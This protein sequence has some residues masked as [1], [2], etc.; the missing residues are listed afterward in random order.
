MKARNQVNEEIKPINLK[1][2]K[3][4]EIYAYLP[5]GVMVLME[6]NP[7]VIERIIDAPAAAIWRALTDPDE[8]KG[9]YFD[10]PDFKAVVGF[11]FQF[12]AG[13]GQEKS[14]VH[15]CEVLEVIPETKL[16]YS[17]RYEGYGGNSILTFELKPLSE[18]RTIVRLTHAGLLSFPIENPDLAPGNFVV[19]WNYF[20][21]TGLPDYVE[22]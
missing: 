12:S 7:L 2:E 6:N 8:M 1:T 3:L 5:P 15:L 22:V 14:Y 19:G 10:I 4:F 11:Q 13:E 21:G 17:W 9:W 20:M 18:N 16:S